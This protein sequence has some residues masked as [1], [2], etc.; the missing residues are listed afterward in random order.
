ME[1][2]NDEISLIPVKITKNNITK[3]TID[4]FV[5]EIDYEKKYTLNDL[6]KLLTVAFKSVKQKKK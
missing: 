1:P 5:K 6:K 4:T 3:I 2:K